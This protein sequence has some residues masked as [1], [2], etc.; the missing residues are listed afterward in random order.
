MDSCQSGLHDSKLH[1]SLLKFPESNVNLCD[2]CYCRITD[3]ILERKDMTM[4]ILYRWAKECGDVPQVPAPLRRDGLKISELIQFVDQEIGKMRTG[5]RDFPTILL[6][7]DE[8][9]EFIQILGKD[10]NTVKRI[11][12][13]VS[14]DVLRESICLRG[15]SGCL[16]AS[17]MLR[18]KYVVERNPD[19][20]TK[21]EELISPKM[22]ED[23]FAE[24]AIKIQ[25]PIYEAGV[26]AAV[27]WQLKVIGRPNK[28][29]YLDGV[30]KNSIVWEYTKD[31]NKKIISE[32]DVETSSENK[33][34]IFYCKDTDS[35]MPSR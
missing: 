16:D 7:P 13:C 1:L 19:G 28:K 11:L 14:N 5:N 4:E 18:D 26:K 17:K 27:V 31:K 30:P 34:N 21:Q 23:A 25:D 29:I 15:W 20:S 22:R 12:P 8:K 33:E 32:G 24:M 35:C 6:R 2:P 3:S 10:S 9:N